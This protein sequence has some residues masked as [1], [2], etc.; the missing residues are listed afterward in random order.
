[1]RASTITRNV[2]T[3]LTPLVKRSTLDIHSQRYTVWR[4]TVT[5]ASA[6]PVVRYTMW[7]MTRRAP[8]HYRQSTHEECCA[9]LLVIRVVRAVRTVG[10]VRITGHIESFSFL[11]VAKNKINI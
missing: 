4:M 3:T 6:P 11:N 9:G 8:V 7:S 2:I 1:M 5:P 10:A